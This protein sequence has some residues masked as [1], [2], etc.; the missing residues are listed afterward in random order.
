MTNKVNGARDKD[1]FDFIELVYPENVGIKKNN[2]LS[3]TPNDWNRNGQF[4][5][6]ATL[7][8]KVNGA[9][10]KDNFDLIEIVYPE[11]VGIKK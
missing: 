11:N 2:L 7:T 4:S 3:T 9:R 1:N 5:G 10:D 8:N 6:Q